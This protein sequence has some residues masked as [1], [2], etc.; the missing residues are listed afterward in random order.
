MF[1]AQRDVW[2]ERGVWGVKRGVWDTKG[3]LW[4]KW[5]FVGRER[6]FGGVKG[7]LAVKGV[8]GA[9]RGICGA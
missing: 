1:G 6:V 2:G 4:L 7:Y 3:C 8:F 9:E 5:V